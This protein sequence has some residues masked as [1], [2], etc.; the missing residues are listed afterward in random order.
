MRPFPPPTKKAVPGKG[1][2]PA[3]QIRC[4]LL[5]KASF[6]TSLARMRTL[7]NPLRG[8]RAGSALAFSLRQRK[9]Q[10]RLAL[11][12]SLAEGK[13]FEPLC[14]SRHKRFSSF[15]LCLPTCFE[16]CLCVSSRPARKSGIFGEKQRKT[17]VLTRS[18][19]KNQGVD[20]GSNN[21]VFFPKA[22]LF[23]RLGKKSGEKRAAMFSHSIFGNY[24]TIIIICQGCVG[25]SSD[26]EKM[27][28]SINYEA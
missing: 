18:D 3:A 22:L 14:D 4:S 16:P 13:G 1:Y 26:C 7:R 2:A 11:L 19:T 10:C 5:W 21:T 27:K 8:I 6:P 15:L 20:M 28:G 23:L 9:K 25:C 12:F 24:N 17:D